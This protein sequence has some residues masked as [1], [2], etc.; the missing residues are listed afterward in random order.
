MNLR[1]VD[2]VI[3]RLFTLTPAWLPQHLVGLQLVHT[4]TLLTAPSPGINN[5]TYSK[6]STLNTFLIV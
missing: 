4:K 3:Q 5:F 1:H 6:N 2:S